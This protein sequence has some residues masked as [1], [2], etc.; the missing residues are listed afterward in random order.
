[1][2]S[3][4]EKLLLDLLRFSDVNDLHLWDSS[5]LLALVLFHRLWVILDTL[6]VCKDLHLLGYHPNMANSFVEVKSNPV[7]DRVSFVGVFLYFFIIFI[8]KPYNSFFLFVCNELVTFD[9]VIRI[10]LVFLPGF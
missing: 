6:S 1:M 3:W 7:Q 4:K 10:F 9:L 2:L 5:V 8:T